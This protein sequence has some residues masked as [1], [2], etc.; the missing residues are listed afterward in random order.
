T[1]I[2]SCTFTHC[3]PDTPPADQK[4]ISLATLKRMAMAEDIE[5]RSAVTAHPASASL[6][7]VR[8]R[9]DNEPMRSTSPAPRPAPAKDRSTSPGLDGDSIKANPIDIMK[10][11]PAVTPIMEGEASAFLVMPCMI[12]PDTAKEP[13]INAAAKALG[14]R[15]LWIIWC[16]VES[17]SKRTN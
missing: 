7:G 12:A 16:W 17:A 4:L 14:I 11:A 15:S 8:P 6:T 13:P 3:T 1:G 2:R 9:L 10:V 5:L